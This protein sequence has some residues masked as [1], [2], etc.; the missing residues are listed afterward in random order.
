MCSVVKQPVIQTVKTQSTIKL[1]TEA[2][3]TS[4]LAVIKF[5]VFYLNWWSGILSI[6]SERVSLAV[7]TLGSYSGVLDS[8]PGRGTGYP[9]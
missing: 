1:K 9:D 3:F 4:L 2:H 6:S 8:N 5:T 7:T